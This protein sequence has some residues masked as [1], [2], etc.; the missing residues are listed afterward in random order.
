MSS[1]KIKVTIK[2]KIDITA[3]WAKANPVLAD[4][5]RGIERTTDGLI[6]EKV[7]D[8]K[9][10]WNALP[11]VPAK[12]ATT[13]T[14][15]GTGKNIANTYTPKSS[16]AAVATSG[17]YSDLTG[18][19]TITAPPTKLSQL[20]NDSGFITEDTAD[21][22]YLG[23]NS[24]AKSAG[25]AD[26]AAKATTSSY[27]SLTYGNEIALDGSGLQ[28]GSDGTANINVGYRVDNAKAGFAGIKAYVFRN[29]MKA[30][31]FANVQAAT[32]IGALQGTAD[33]AKQAAL[34]TVTNVGT[35]AGK[36]IAEFK[37]ILLAQTTAVVN[38]KQGT[39]SIQAEPT[40]LIS[41]WNAGNDDFV[42]TAGGSQF[43]TIECRISSPYASLEWR[44]YYTGVRYR[45]ILSNGK[46][47]K[48]E[49]VVETVNGILT[50]DR[51]MADSDGNVLQKTYAKK[52][53]IPASPDLTPYAKKTDIPTKL[54]SPNA[55]T[56]T[57]G[58][59]GTYDGSKA[60][61]VTIPA[62]PDLTQYAKKTELPTVPS[63]T[64]QLTN[65]SGYIKDTDVPLMSDADVQASFDDAN[66]QIDDLLGLHGVY[67]GT[68]APA[69]KNF[70]LWIKPIE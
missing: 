39:I 48:W 38:Y 56:F 42:I 23:V 52:T 25:T 59:T 12:I 44:T 36:T 55:V 21:A 5:E 10:A 33:N 61:T 67:V 2:H 31:P 14:N 30:T 45:C 27:V 41:N 63:K 15:D 22:T 28:I 53:D 49:K 13:A 65:D 24:K 57:G 29:G 3:N 50:A 46:W 6:Y 66:A 32:F 19:P 40:K 64:S 60:V 7:G 68:E 62:A 17:K 37:D 26:T 20:Q 8:G 11:Y 69:S 9:T 16:L 34:T 43:I 18:T 47:G 35:M 51:A 54:P 4:G 1:N 70:S 58:A